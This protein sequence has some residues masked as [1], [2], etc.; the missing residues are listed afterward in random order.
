MNIEYIKKLIVKIGFVPEN[1]KN[2]VYV[3]Q[4]PAHNNYAIYVDFNECKIE[5]ACQSVEPN[6]RIRIGDLTTSN[7]DKSENFVVLECVDRLLTK[8]YSPNC[9][10]LEKKYP[11]GRNLKGKLDILVY[12]ETGSVP[13][14]MVECKTWG[15]EYEKELSKTLKD[16]GQIFSYYQQDK[17]AKY[18][19]LYASHLDKKE[20]EYYLMYT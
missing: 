16:G 11:L 5:Y 1:G 4:Y 7:F 9:L 10:E 6:K 14:L 2:A 20:I 17:A 18:L 3:K 19:C 8:G 12:D 13:F 15:T